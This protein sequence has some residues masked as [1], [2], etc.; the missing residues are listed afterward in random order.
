MYLHRIC[1]DDE[2]GGSS[3]THH[4]SGRPVDQRKFE[5]SLNKIGTQQPAGKWNKETENDQAFP[6][7]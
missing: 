3:P 2:G 7:F 1:E 5:G 4:Q 6:A